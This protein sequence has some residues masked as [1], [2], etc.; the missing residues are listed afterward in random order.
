[1]AQ[2]V[3]LDAVVASRFHNV[4]CALKCGVPTIAVGYGEKH[5]VLME[6]FGVGRFTHDIRT[7][8][9]DDLAR[10]LESLLAEGDRFSARLLEVAAAEQRTLVA[11]LSAVDDLVPAGRDRGARP[12]VG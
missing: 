3:D 9:V 2:V 1:M 7:L 10:S 6:R 5:R 11:H 4:L 12:T 8:D